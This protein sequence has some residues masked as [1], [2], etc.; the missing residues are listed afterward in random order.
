MFMKD[1]LTFVVS[2]ILLCAPSFAAPPQSADTAVIEKFIAKQATQEDG[3]EYAGARQVTAG[4]LN[5]DGVPDVAVLYTI[6]G[7]N[8]TNNYVQ[9][10][11]AFVRTRRGLD[12]MAHT[13]AGGK[14][15]RDVDLMSIKNNVIH[16]KTLSRQ[17]NDPTSTPSKKGTARFVLV[18][19]RLKEL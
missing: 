11:A 14:W 2:I 10:L 5:H 3:E 19:R 6:E 16:L 7:Q 9:Y 13:F 4:D 12:P 17:A 15:N 18:K 8:G 1:M